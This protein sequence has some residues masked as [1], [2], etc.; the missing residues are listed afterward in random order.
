MAYTREA[1][2]QLIVD[3]SPETHRRRFQGQAERSTNAI[4]SKRLLGSYDDGG[5]DDDDD[6]D[7]YGDDD[8]DDDGDIRSGNI[9]KLVTLL[10][11]PCHRQLQNN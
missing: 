8:D 4:E 2:L 6:D 5:N 11:S 1:L 10:P 3:L 7:C 9:A